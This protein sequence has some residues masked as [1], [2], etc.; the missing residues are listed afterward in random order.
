MERSITSLT[1]A[2]SLM[3]GLAAC[4]VDQT[5]TEEDTSPAGEVT[6]PLCQIGYY[7]CPT[8]GDVPMYRHHYCPGEAT[9]ARVE[10]K[11]FCNGVECIRV[12]L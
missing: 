2:F 5:A 4:G 7:Y 12:S 3:T 1:L 6:A 9:T 10:C 8:Y 11:E